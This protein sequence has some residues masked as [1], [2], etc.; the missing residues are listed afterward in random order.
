LCFKNNS[1]VKRSDDLLCVFITDTQIY[2]LDILPH[3]N[4]KKPKTLLDIIC[5]NFLDISRNYL[6]K[7]SY[8][9]YSQELSDNELW[10]SISGN[11]IPIIK[12][13]D[14]YNYILRISTDGSDPINRS[15]YDRILDSRDN[16]ISNIIKIHANINKNDP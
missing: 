13:C 4:W 7:F 10:S 2:M 12:L 14:G 9:G 1:F 8:D 15:I 6:F 11:V 16:Y 3:N 5:K